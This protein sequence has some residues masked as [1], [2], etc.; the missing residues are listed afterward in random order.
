MKKNNASILVIGNEILS[1]KTQDLNTQYIANELSELG[2]V[3][4]EVRMIPDQEE[5]IITHINELRAKYK[6]VFTTGGIGP[7][8]DD[9]TTMSVAKAFNIV[10]AYNSEALAIIE[11]RSRKMGKELLEP[12][13]KMALI[14]VGATLIK[15]SET[16]APGFRIENVYV[17]AGIP[18]VMQAMFNEVKKMI[19]EDHQVQAFISKS[20]D[21]IL[22]E[23]LI[24]EGFAA[25]QKKFPGIEM[26]SYP[27]KKNNIWETSLVLRSKNKEAIEIA[28][29]ELEQMLK[30]IQK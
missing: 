15:N 26:G 19:L 12:S 5:E 22:G 7:T 20:I 9:I 28:M 21:V 4:D 30:E 27:H 18:K 1:G 6:Y 3:L 25:L 14:P 17:M 2:I 13:K 11:E 10:A 29:N 24:S 16:G 8:H 23:S